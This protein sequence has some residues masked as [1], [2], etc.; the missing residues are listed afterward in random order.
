ME[1]KIKKLENK[2]DNYNNYIDERINQKINSMNNQNIIN[3]QNMQPQINQQN[4]MNPQMNQSMNF[5]NIN[6]NN[7]NYNNM[8][9]NMNMNP[10]NNI[11]NNSISILF[12]M[13]D[14]SYPP[15]NVICQPEE[16]VFD[17]VKKYRDNC[18]NYEKNMRFLYRGEGLEYNK[19]K[20][21]SKVIV[22]NIANVLVVRT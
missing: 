4:I 12:R 8:N 11:N 1:D 3:Q 13:N 2:L 15:L 10:M 6:N 17:M 20:P 16:K 18:G 7:I 19:D 22:G 21:I 5:Q 14:S 9:N